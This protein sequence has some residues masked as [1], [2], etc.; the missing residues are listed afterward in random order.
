[1]VAITSSYSITQAAFPTIYSWRGENGNMVFSENKPSSDSD[2]KVIS[3]DKPTVVD[4]KRPQHS[5][6]VKDVKIE[7]SDIEKLVNAKLAEENK[8]VLDESQVSTYE[9]TITSPFLN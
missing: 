5:D 4:T 8:Q 6:D 1:M 3:V 7:Q 2:Y 9:V